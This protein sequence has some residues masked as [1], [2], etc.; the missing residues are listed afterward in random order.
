MCALSFFIT[1]FQLA[2]LDKSL[3][4]SVGFVKCSGF[5]VTFVLFEYCHSSVTAALRCLQRLLSIVPSSSMLSLL[6]VQLL[7]ANEA[8]ENA[9]K[10]C[11]TMFISLRFICKF[12]LKHLKASLES[13]PKDPLLYY[14]AARLELKQV[15]NNRYACMSINVKFFF[16]PPAL[17]RWQI[18]SLC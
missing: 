11:T 5:Y 12:L 9:W 3:P 4:Q 1:V 6:Y 17:T 14:L 18:R 16:I 2:C 13:C 10:V 7:S 15:S 8:K